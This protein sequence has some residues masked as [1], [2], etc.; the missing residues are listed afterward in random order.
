MGEQDGS[1]HISEE[2]GKTEQKPGGRMRP[3]GPYVMVRHEVLVF[4]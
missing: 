2:L 4:L 1:L 3:N